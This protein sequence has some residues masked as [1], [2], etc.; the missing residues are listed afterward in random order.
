MNIETPSLRNRKYEVIILVMLVSILILFVL[1]MYSFYVDSVSLKENTFSAQKKGQDD[2]EMIHREIDELR[3]R[4]RN[5]E[6]DF[7][8]Q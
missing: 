1:G 4:I 6:G 5:L 2:R 3:E 7:K 8:V